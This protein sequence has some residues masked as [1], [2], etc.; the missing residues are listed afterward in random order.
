M[1]SIDDTHIP[2]TTNGMGGSETGML[3][4]NGGWRN[5]G[6]NGLS[7]KSSSVT[8]IKLNF[9]AVKSLNG[10]PQ[11]RELIRTFVAGYKLIGEQR[12]NYGQQ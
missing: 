6:F 12:N 8:R 4:S 2:D 7:G 5:G 3:E 10:R 9:V 1:H 11:I